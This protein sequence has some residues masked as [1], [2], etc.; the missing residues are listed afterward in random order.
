[1]ERSSELQKILF[2]EKLSDDEH[3]TEGIWCLREGDKYVVDN[4]PFVARRISLGDKIKAEYDADENVYYFDDFVK[5]S[6]NTTVRLYFQDIS[7]I[8]D[9]GRN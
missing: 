7:I 5:V 1:M 2:I 6:G 8:E 3:E 9:T 4:I